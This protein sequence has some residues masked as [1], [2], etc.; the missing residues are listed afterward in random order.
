MGIACTITDGQTITH[1]CVNTQPNHPQYDNIH[2]MKAY[3]EETF[4]LDA[5]FIWYD[6]GAY[7]QQGQQMSFTLEGKASKFI[8]TIWNT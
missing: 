8:F 1:G 5:P 4:A 7:E 2:K 6:I 3:L